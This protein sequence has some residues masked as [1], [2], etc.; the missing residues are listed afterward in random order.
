M[1]YFI[2]SVIGGVLFVLFFILIGVFLLSWAYSGFN[3]VTD[4]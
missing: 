2:F 1:T 3:D 4:R